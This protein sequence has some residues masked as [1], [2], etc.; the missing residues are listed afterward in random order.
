[1]PID[2][3]VSCSNAVDIAWAPEADETDD[4]GLSP[5]KA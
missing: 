1:M 2:V 4:Q 3:Y 5:A